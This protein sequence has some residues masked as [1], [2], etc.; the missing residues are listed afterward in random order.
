[1]RD[2]APYSIYLLA[3]YCTMWGVPL[4]VMFCF[5]H[6]GNSSYQLGCTV[7]A[8]SAQRPVEHV[9]NA[10][11]NIVNEG[12]PHSVYL[13]LLDRRR[14]PDGARR[15]RG[16]EA[17]VVELEPRRLR[18]R[19][20]GGPLARVRS[21]NPVLVEVAG[22]LDALLPNLGFATAASGEFL[23]LGMLV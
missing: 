3:E 21:S 16:D 12:M 14:G 10:L 19:P 17:D 2:H 4:F 18:P 7:A 5:V 6:F 1:M 15:G 23:K 11:Q 22:F 13:S 20:L 9:K 8:V